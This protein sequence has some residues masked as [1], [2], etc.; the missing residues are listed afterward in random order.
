MIRLRLA[1][2]GLLAGIVLVGPARSEEDEAIFKS[3]CARCHGETGTSDTPG[4]RAL[5]VRPLVNDPAVAAMTPRQIV[6]AIKSGPKHRGVASGVYELGD[7]DLER[8]AA[9]ARELAKRGGS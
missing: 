9:F 8:A 1:L 3:H 7:A 5:K 6:D 4:A 2:V